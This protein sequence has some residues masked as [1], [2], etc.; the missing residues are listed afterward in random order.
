[1]PRLS[2]EARRRVLSLHSRG[3]S[4]SSIFRRLQQENVDVSKCATYKL[5]KKWKLKSTVKDLPRQKTPQILIPEM[6]AMIEEEYKKNDELTSFY[7]GFTLCIIY[8]IIV[9]HC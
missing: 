6:K 4:V 1:M 7:Y 8:F 9:I 2:I 3:Y 5:V